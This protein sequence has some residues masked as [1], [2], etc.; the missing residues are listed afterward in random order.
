MYIFFTLHITKSTSFLIF[1]IFICIINKQNLPLLK[2]ILK[3][4]IT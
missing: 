2:C 3:Q 4:Q 1:N